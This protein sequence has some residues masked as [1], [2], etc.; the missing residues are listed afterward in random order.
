MARK[1]N[2]NNL[3]LY[4]I[5]KVKSV[6]TPRLISMQTYQNLFDQAIDR[7]KLRY[8][9]DHTDEEIKLLKEEIAKLKGVDADLNASIE[10]NATKCEEER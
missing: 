3:A 4:E 5:D 7:C 2:E 6:R 1:I 9:Q 10:A 8:R